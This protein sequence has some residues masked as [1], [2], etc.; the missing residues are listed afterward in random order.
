[1]DGGGGV[2]C[3]ADRIL[4]RRQEAYWCHLFKED[5][6]RSEKETV[7]GDGVEFPCCRLNPQVPSFNYPMR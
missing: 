2:S 7:D 1:M 6:R 3:V 5:Q 4:G